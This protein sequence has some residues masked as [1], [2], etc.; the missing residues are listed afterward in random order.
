MTTVVTNFAVKHSPMTTVITHHTV[1]Q[2]PMT[3]AITY[4]TA[5]QSPMT[6]LSHIIELSSHLRLQ[7]LYTIQLNSQI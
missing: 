4:H 1:K 6:M 3:T 5:K 7:L 2:S